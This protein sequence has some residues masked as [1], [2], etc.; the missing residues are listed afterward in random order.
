MSGVDRV[1]GLYEIEVEAWNGMDALMR[2]SNMMRRAK[3]DYKRLNASFDERMVRL[4]VEAL[5]SGPEV[6]WLTVK[7]SRMP[8]TH[9]V[10]ARL[11]K[12]LD[13]MVTHVG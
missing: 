12:L 13:K 9:R 3:L 11:L 8:E 7:L 10:E 6:R 2:I 4:R 5:G 1:Y